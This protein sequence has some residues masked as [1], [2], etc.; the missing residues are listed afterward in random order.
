MEEHDRQFRLAG[1]NFEMIKEEIGG[2]KEGLRQGKEDSGRI[3]K[4][5]YESFFFTCVESGLAAFRE[6]NYTMA[7]EIFTRALKYRSG[8]TTVKFYQ[9]Y[10]FY[11]GAAGRGIGA[12]DRQMIFEAVIELERLGFRAGERLDF[13]EDEMRRRVS[14]IAYNVVEFH[15]AGAGDDL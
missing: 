7:Y 9:I 15:G 1:A 6:G 12:A 8:D 2:V 5:L 13:S 4:L 10:S 14:D 3:I 11:L